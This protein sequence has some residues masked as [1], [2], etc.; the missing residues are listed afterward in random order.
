MERQPDAATPRT[1]T[2]WAQHRYGGPDVVAAEHAAVPSPERA[3]VLLKVRATGLNAADARLLR[4]DPLLIRLF[5]GLRR[6]KH[7]VRGMDVAG[8]VVA[9]G[10]EVREVALGDEVVGELSGGGLAPF[11][12]APVARLVPRP[13]TVAPEAAA[14]LPM[15]GGTAWQALELA[16]VPEGSRV[17]VVG[18]GGVVGT[19]TVQLA[20]HRG[21][22]V[23]ALAGARALDLVTSLGAARAFDYAAVQPGSPELPPDSFDAVFDIAGTA[24]LRALQRLVRRGG[25]V[26]LVTGHG[27]RVLGPI[28]RILRGALLSIGSSRGIRPLSATAKPDVLRELLDLVAEGAVRPVVERTYLL[29]SAR[30]ALAHVDGGHTLG[31]VVVVAD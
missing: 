12:I 23:W 16:A 5:F 10:S 19:F 17:L 26:V 29:D 15:A 13:R 20:A 30:D 24:P 4:G 27:G 7:A 3:E 11:A 28:G 8:T 2:V 22:E 1:M 14:A 25:R 6:P 31:K 9:L 21:L 18:A